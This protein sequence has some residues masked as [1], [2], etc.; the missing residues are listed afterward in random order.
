MEPLVCRVE[1][2]PRGGAVHH[3]DELAQAGE[4]GLRGGQ[5]GEMRD[6]AL[7]QESAVDQVV[8]LGGGAPVGVCLADAAEPGLCRHERPAVAA[9]AALEDPILGQGGE[10]ASDGYFADIHG[11]GDLTRRRESFARA[12]ETQVD[13][14]GCLLYTSDA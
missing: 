12:Q 14:H 7:E 6:A 2:G 3:V 5:R 4:L 10:C 1:R 8:N 13:S 11:L 9:A